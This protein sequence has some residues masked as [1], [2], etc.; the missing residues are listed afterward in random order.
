MPQDGREDSIIC[1]WDERKTSALVFRTDRVQTLG[2]L[3]FELL[4]VS[5]SAVSAGLLLA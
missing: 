1:Q 5:R 2:V 4:P 3:L